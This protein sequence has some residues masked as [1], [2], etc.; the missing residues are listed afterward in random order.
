MRRFVLILLVVILVL[1]AGGY[2]AIQ[3]QVKLAFPQTSGELQLPGLQSKVTVV[4]DPRGIPHIYA[5]NSHDLFMAQGFVQAQDRFWQ[6]EFWRRIGAGRLSELFGKSSL[7]QDRFLRTIGITRSAELTWEALDADTQAALQAYADGVNVYIKQNAKR[8]PLEFR[9]LG[10]TGVHFTPEPW[11]PINTLTWTTM[12]SYDL[13]GNYEMEL[14]RAELLARYGE[15]WMRELTDYPYPDDHPLILPDFVSWNQIDFDSVAQAPTSLILGDGEGIG[16]NNWVVN[17]SKTDTGMPLLA[18]DPHLGIRMPSIWYEN[19]LH[20]V[21]LTADCPYNVVGFSFPS[22]P[23]V[24]IGHNNAIAWGVTNAYPD[25]QDLFIEKINP[26]NP[27]QYEMDGQWQDMEIIHD[28]IVVAGQEDP[29]PLTIRRT[30]HGPILN[31]VAYGTESDWAYGWQPLAL[32]WTALGVN[33]ISQA[34]L[35][36]DR[37]QNWQEFRTALHDW[38][39]PSQNFV[40]ADTEGNIGYQMPGRIPIRSQSDGLLPVPGWDSRYDWQTYVPFEALPSAFNPDRGFIVTANNLVVAPSYPYL[41]RH[42]GAPGFRAERITEM[43]TS[44]EVLSLADMRVIQGDNANLLARDLIPLLQNV[45]LARPEVAAAR[46]RLL[47]WDYQE[48]MDSNPAV[49]FEA[50]WYEL[51]TALFADELGKE[52]RRDREL[53]R[54][55]AFDPSS[56]WWDNVHTPAVETRDDIFAQ[57]M[58]DAYDLLVKKQGKKIDDWRWGKV[59]TATFRNKTL[60][61]SGVSLIE[62]IFNRGPYETSGGNNIVNATSWSTDP[63]HL[64]QVRAVPSMRMIVDLADFN[65]SITINTTGQSGHPYHPHYDDQIDNWRFIQYAPMFWDRAQLEAKAEDTLILSP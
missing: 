31:D 58:N 15:T 12:M 9:V 8:L 39:S 50:F 55:L 26:E 6:M 49:F 43:L 24:V 16:S 54:Q 30:N 28:E 56:H 14:T 29:V 22:S 53:I 44:K 18:N 51:P 41:T 60:G 64:F 19:G 27:N 33:R 40:Y 63:D 37:A 48:G 7:G 2:F 62:K 36:I 42:E 35:K 57:A 10:L 46:D 3:H 23:G 17:G 4:R 59:H 61:M 1:A 65:R 20:C 11:T 52:V 38:D 21:E 25:V 32:Q 13:G 34:I 5:H 45:P 47:S